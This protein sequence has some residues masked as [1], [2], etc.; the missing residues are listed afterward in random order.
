MTPPRARGTNPTIGASRRAAEPPGVALSL[1]TASSGQSGFVT[2][3]AAAS[4]RQRRCSSSLRWRA[5]TRRRRAYASDATGSAE[6]RFCW[7]SAAGISWPSTETPA[8]LQV[9]Q[10]RLRMSIQVPRWA[11]SR[12]RPSETPLLAGSATTEHAAQSASQLERRGRVRAVDA[13]HVLQRRS[14][15]RRRPPQ[16]LP[17][18]RESPQPLDVHAAENASWTA[19]VGRANI[20]TWPRA[21]TAG[22][23]RWQAASCS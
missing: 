16:P 14:A 21:C 17:L 6:W 23:T 3:I 18:V 9:R 13:D 4:L 12:D 5:R 10:P 11:G 22:N 20:G 15:V 7:S 1:P 2:T 19:G 8:S